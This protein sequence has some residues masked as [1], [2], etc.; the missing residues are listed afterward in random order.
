M[1][2][3]SVTAIV[4]GSFACTVNNLLADGTKT[5]TVELGVALSATLGQGTGSGQ[6]DRAWSE[7]SRSLTGGTNEDLDLYDLGT[8]DIGAGAGLDA[9]GQAWAISE[10]VGILIYNAGPGLLTV[11]PSSSNGW[12]PL[13]GA[14]G[15]HA[16][17]AGG[18]IQ[19]Y[20]P[21]DPAFAV[22]DASSHQLNFAASGG[23]VVYDVHLVA[24]SA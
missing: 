23:N 14:S 1:G 8:R 4:K 3:R 21:A 5:P 16:I 9:M 11:T 15:S 12:T 2:T 19:A 22:T 13:L 20:N 10:V 18:F 7:Y 6:C 24:R 17:G